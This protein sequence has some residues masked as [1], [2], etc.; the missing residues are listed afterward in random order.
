MGNKVCNRCGEKKP[1][2]KFHMTSRKEFPGSNRRLRYRRSVC[3]ECT[4]KA[5]RVS[6]KKSPGVKRYNPD[7]RVSDFD[8]CCSSINWWLK[9]RFGDDCG[10]FAVQHCL[11]WPS[12]SI[13]CGKVCVWAPRKNY[14]T[15]NPWNCLRLLNAC[16]EI[17]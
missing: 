13:M 1:E 4:N 2:T 16:G 15:P 17:K 10:S 14:H 3:A 12:K 7:T 8:E 9:E 5:K 6:V 11:N